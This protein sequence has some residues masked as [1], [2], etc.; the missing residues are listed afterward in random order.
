MRHVVDRK[1]G[2]AQ[3]SRSPGK[4]KSAREMKGNGGAEFGHVGGMIRDAEVLRD[5][6]GL[7]AQRARPLFR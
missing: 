1:T 5:G 7:S 6:C 2:T 3:G 4:G